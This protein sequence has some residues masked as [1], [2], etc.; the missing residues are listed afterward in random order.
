MDFRQ[1]TRC[2][3]AFQLTMTMDRSGRVIEKPSPFSIAGSALGPNLD[4]RQ[5]GMCLLNETVGYAITPSPIR[6]AALTR[7]R[8]GWERARVRAP[9]FRNGLAFLAL[10]PPVFPASFDR[11]P[12]PADSLP[13]PPPSLV[14]QSAHRV[15]TEIEFA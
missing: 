5:S 13:C 7:R 2:D 10:L 9:S 11:Q 15:L 6:L 1:L 4:V 3:R 12:G 8:S 14:C